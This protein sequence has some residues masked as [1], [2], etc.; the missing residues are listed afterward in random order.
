MLVYINRKQVTDSKPKDEYVYRMNMGI[1]DAVKEGVPQ[2]YVDQTMR[3]F[4]PYRDYDEVREVA[5][6]QVLSLEDER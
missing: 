5:E 6:Q 4:I 1:K 2:E 3:P